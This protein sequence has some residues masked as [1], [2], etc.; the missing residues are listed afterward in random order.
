MPGYRLKGQFTWLLTLLPNIA[1]KSLSFKKASLTGGVSNSDYTFEGVKTVKVYS[2]GT[3]ALADYNRSGT[4]RYGTPAE[5]SDTIQEFTM[6][7]DKA[8]TYTIDK[9]N[10]AEQLNIKAATKSLRREIDEVVIPAM[11][12]YRFGV[13]CKKAGT[14]KGLAAAPNKNT[15]TA[16]IMDSTEVLDDALVP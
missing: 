4:S 9:G 6:T 8:F 5:L 2:V 11:D 7:Q 10:E 14:I 13:W 16:L 15:I 3:V 1:T 12:K